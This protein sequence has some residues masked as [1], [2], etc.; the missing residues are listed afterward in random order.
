MTTAPKRPPLR[1]SGVD[2]LTRAVRP[3]MLIDRLLARRGVAVVAAPPYTGKTFFALEAMRTVVQGGHFA[4]GPAFKAQRPG[5]VLYLGNDSPDWDLASQFDK[6]IGLPDPKTHDV[7]RL[8]DETDLGSYGF[9][10]EPGFMLNSGEDAER[11]IDAAKVRASV[12]DY[13]RAFVGGEDTEVYR[14]VRGTDLIV[15]DTLRSVHGFEENDNTGMQ[16]VMNLLRYIATETGAGVL[17]LHH[18]NKGTKESPQ[19]SLERLRGATAIGGAVDSV[20]ALT[21]KL[22]SVAVR[23][24][25]HRPC[26][27][28]SDFV[29][30]FEQSKDRVALRLESAEG[31]MN[32][33]ARKAVL[34]LLEA[35]H[36]EWVRTNELQA[37]VGGAM[38]EIASSK[39]VV[40]ATGKVLAALEKNGNVVRIHG[41]ARLA[42]AQVGGDS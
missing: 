34:E 13:T 15:I 10:F 27:E 33:A 35:N 23:V 11:V 18:F 39:K 12:R 5:N 26:P 32:L 17:A 40:N 19:A 20:F 25:K 29:Y 4:G 8:M 31:I 37:A 1:V 36:G 38:N 3:E 28:Q 14:P 9:I 16:H 22:P 41:A 7:G 42:D 2:R 21:G 6:L 30:Q 24:L